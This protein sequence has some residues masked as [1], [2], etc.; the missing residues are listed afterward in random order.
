MGEKDMEYLLYIYIYITKHVISL[1]QHAPTKC[2]TLGCR[3]FELIRI[4]ALN[5]RTLSSVT[6]NMVLMATLARVCV[7]GCHLYCVCA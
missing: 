7:L 4:S 6:S 1:C 5:A 2:T 3:R